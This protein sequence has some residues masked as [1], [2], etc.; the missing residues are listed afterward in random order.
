MNK[1]LYINTFPEQPFPQ[2]AQINSPQITQIV[3]ICAH[4]L[5]SALSAGKAVRLLLH[6][7]QLHYLSFLTGNH[8]R[9]IGSC[10]KFMSNC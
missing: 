1:W 2:M 6:F 7:H 3:L 4:L 10:P 8:L 9:D 5:K